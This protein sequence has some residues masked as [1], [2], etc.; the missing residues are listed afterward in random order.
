MSL[1]ILR[2][3]RDSIIDTL[4]HGVVEIADS[5]GIVHT[6]PMEDHK[7]GA[8]TGELYRISSYIAEHAADEEVRER[9]VT[10]KLQGGKYSVDHAARLKKIPAAIIHSWIRQGLVAEKGGLVSMSSLESHMGTR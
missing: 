8:L 2:S 6:Y 3:Y 9:T 10:R 1:R 5:S 7:R 4:A